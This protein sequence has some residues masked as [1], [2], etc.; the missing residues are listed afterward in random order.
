MHVG[1]KELK[2]R[3]SHYLRKVKG[4]EVIRVTDRGEVIAEIRAALPVATD[5]HE[6]LTQLE[7]DGMVTTGRARFATFRSV[8]LRK[9]LRASRAILEDRG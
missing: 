9:G 1:T 2:N 3:L 8:R 5:E 6:I 4:G 7:A